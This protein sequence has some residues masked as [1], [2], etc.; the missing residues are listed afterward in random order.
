MGTET[1]T[2]KSF[3][4]FFVLFMSEILYSYVSYKC[5]GDV[6]IAIKKYLRDV[7]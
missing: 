7:K 6:C 2:G 3:L 5:H 4:P 1:G